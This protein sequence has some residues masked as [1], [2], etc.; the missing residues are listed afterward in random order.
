MFLV[1]AVLVQTSAASAKC[2][3]PREWY[4]YS[5]ASP[6]SGASQSASLVV[7]RDVSDGTV[8]YLQVITSGGVHVVFTP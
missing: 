8:E 4:S 2:E 1:P 3:D 7:N 6:D 5:A